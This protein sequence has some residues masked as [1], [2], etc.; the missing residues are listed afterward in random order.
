MDVVAVWSNAM[1]T[2]PRAIIL[3][4]VDSVDAALKNEEE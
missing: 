3:V 1:D 4:Y 2:I